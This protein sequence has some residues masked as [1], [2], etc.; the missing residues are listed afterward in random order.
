MFDDLFGPQAK[1]ATA[2]DAY[3]DRMEKCLQIKQLAE[4]LKISEQIDKDMTE[5]VK[6]LI[7]VTTKE[8]NKIILAVKA[9]EESKEKKED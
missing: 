7:E 8:A 2:I 1:A 3:L 5:M 4:S 9:E 6:V